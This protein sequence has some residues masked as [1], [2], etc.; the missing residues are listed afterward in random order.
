MRSSLFRTKVEQAPDNLLF[1]FSLAQALYQENDY[2]KACE[3]LQV[4]C[5]GR[6]DWMLA[7]ILL[8]KALL[9]LGRKQEAQPVLEEALHL[10]I[11]QHH[12]DPADELR[13]LLRQED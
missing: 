12:D 1:R 4:C 7:K 13:T 5:D 2:E 9:A 3:H 6:K 10:A 11:E 8:G